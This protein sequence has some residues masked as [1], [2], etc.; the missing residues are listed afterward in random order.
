MKFYVEKNTKTVD[1][2]DK[3]IVN[4]SDFPEPSQVFK[5][6]IE[7]HIGFGTSSKFLT[8]L[9]E[10]NRTLSELSLQTNFVLVE[11]SVAAKISMQELLK[12]IWDDTNDHSVDA[13]KMTE[14][15]KGLCFVAKKSKKTGSE[16]AMKD[17]EDLEKI[18]TQGIILCLS[19]ILS[20]AYLPRLNKFQ[21]E[22]S[23]KLLNAIKP[24]AV[25]MESQPIRPTSEAIFD[26]KNMVHFYEL[27]EQ[28]SLKEKV[29]SQYYKDLVYE[30]TF[31]T[32]PTET[33]SKLT[34]KLQERVYVYERTHRAWPKMIL[35]LVGEYGNIVNCLNVAIDNLR[36]E[37]PVAFESIRS[38]FKKALDIADPTYFESFATN[39]FEHVPDLKTDE[40]RLITIE[41]THS[42]HTADESRIMLK[43]L[44]DELKQELDKGS[45]LTG[46]INR[47]FFS[48]SKDADSELKYNSSVHAQNLDYTKLHQELLAKAYGGIITK[49]YLNMFIERRNQIVSI[50]NT[51][52]PVTA[53][54]PKP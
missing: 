48:F 38:C 5:E 37:Y 43:D 32:S 42:L 54:S 47:F 33:L 16:A 49:I 21:V 28:L 26:T 41:L 20:E 4:F 40:H 44:T 52:I 45:K 15:R 17:I 24:K 2:L 14:S 8:F 34:D 11:L 29:N 1:R 19:K 6:M 10:S 13:H 35:K 53:K 22:T 12:L 3:T 50:L 39:I 23:E 18:T 36:K 9:T 27:L 46:A 31:S 30:E 51:F 7:T 25:K